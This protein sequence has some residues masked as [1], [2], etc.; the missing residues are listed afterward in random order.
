MK[1]ASKIFLVILVPFFLTFGCSED[2]AQKIEK[3]FEEAKLLSQTGNAAGALKVS[4]QALQISETE[5]GLENPAIVQPLLKTAMAYQANK[6]YLQAEYTYKRAMD[7]IRKTGGGNTIE[8]AKVMNNLAGL[9]YLQGDYERAIA[10]YEQ[11][12]AIA[13]NTQTPD[14]AMLQQIQRNIIMC[15]AVESGDAVKPEVNQSAPAKSLQDLVPEE[16]KN[17][18]I[19][20]LAGQNIVLAKEFLR[21][22]EP[23][24]IADQ[25]FVFPYYCKQKQETGDTLSEVVVLFGAVK[26]PQKEG[27]YIFKQC[28]VVS[29][30]SF[31]TMLNSGDLLSLKAAMVQIF[32]ELYSS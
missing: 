23:I 2:P 15:K 3:L 7:I 32:P 26:N 17:A 13:K 28:R 1:H 22:F 29:Y 19:Q 5:Y 25:G 21:P 24:K 14:E 12:L 31:S 18:A 11:S 9:F 20:Q 16:I 8:E 4:E 6:N 30:E 27:A 10:T